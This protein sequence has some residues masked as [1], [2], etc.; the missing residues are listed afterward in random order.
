M[1]AE[2]PAAD[3]DGDLHPPA[4]PDNSFYVGKDINSVALTDQN[5]RLS[6]LSIV[7]PKESASL[8]SVDT[9]DR[10]EGLRC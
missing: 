1:T 6:K 8:V 2:I 3:D 7:I 5:S 10:R 9:K 4:S